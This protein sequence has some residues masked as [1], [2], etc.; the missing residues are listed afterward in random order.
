MLIEGRLRENSWEKDGQ[1][2]SR[3]E[4]IANTVKMLPRGSGRKE[5]MAGDNAA[6]DFTPDDITDQEPF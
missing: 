1:R 2:K 5:D 6:S 4:I 3:M